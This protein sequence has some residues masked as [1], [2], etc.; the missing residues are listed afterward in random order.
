[1]KTMTRTV[2]D[3][4]CETQEKVVYDTVWDQQ[5][6]QD[7]KRVAQTQ[8]RQEEFSYQRP[9]YETIT[10]EVPYAVC[11]PVY[12]TRTREV[13]YI[14][15]YP[16]YETRKRSV[17]YTVYRPVEERGVRTISYCVPRQVCYTKTIQVPSGHWETR[18]LSVRARV[19]R[20]M[21]VY[22]NRTAANRM[23]AA[24]LRKA[25]TRARPSKSAIASGYPVSRLVRSRAPRRSTIV[26]LWKFLT[27][28]AEW[29][30][31]RARV[32]WNTRYAAWCQ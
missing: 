16:S 6:V 8:Y 9:V 5:T 23:M 28:T 7:V 3:N 27:A 20:D 25:V 32:R 11:R 29:S 31:R 2:Y 13:N 15:Y 1:M 21:L 4:V 14:C 12:E 24:R 19:A 30:R 17:P 10:R 18:W 26:G 22:R